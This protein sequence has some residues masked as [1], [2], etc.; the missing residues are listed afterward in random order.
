[1]ANISLLA[2]DGTNPKASMLGAADG[3]ER[4]CIN[5]VVINVDWE[6]ITIDTN[7]YVLAQL[8]TG[9]AVINCVWIVTDA[10]SDGVDF[11][12]AASTGAVVSGGDVNILQDDGTVA[13]H[14]VGLYINKVH[15]TNAYGGHLCT[16][17]NYVMCSPTTT[18]T[19]GT[20]TLV[21]EYIKT[22]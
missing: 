4:G 20:G 13:N 16:A 12:I 5:Q 10:F 14:A 3:A 19:S 15:A 9:A 1:M 21:V 18:L 22:L 7:T 17:D 8:P 6:D 2:P 11:G